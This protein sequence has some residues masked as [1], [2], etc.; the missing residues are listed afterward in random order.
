MDKRSRRIRAQQEQIHLHT[1]SHTILVSEIY[2]GGNYDMCNY[3][4]QIKRS[5]VFF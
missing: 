2:F 5:E 3:N 4:H 1:Q